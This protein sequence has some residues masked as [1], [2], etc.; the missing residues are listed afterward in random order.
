M[1]FHT[2][3]ALTAFAVLMGLGAM[4]EARTAAQNCS[5]TLYLTNHHRF[6]LVVAQMAERRRHLVQVQHTHRV[7]NG[8]VIAVAPPAHTIT[9]RRDLQAPHDGTSDDR[10]IVTQTVADVAATRPVA[11]G[12]VGWS[13]SAADL[14]LKHPRT[15][16]LA[17]AQAVPTVSAVPMWYDPA[18]DLENCVRVPFPQCSGGN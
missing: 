14:Y 7:V 5:Q 6:C 10:Y 18:H 16:T 8:H 13:A 15:S 4:S 1:K 17:R 3:L 12:P 11:F 2:G 9:V